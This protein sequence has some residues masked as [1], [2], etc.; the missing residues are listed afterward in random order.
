MPSILAKIESTA[1]A[2]FL[3]SQCWNNA[4][5]SQSLVR[6][7]HSSQLWCVD[8]AARNAKRR[9][10]YANDPEYR[11]RKLAILRK[12]RAK[13]MPAKRSQHIQEYINNPEYRETLRKLYEARNEVR[14]KEAVNQGLA[15]LYRENRNNFKQ[16]NLLLN[17]LMGSKWLRRLAWE[18][19]EPLISEDEK[20][21]AV[22]ASCN[23][24]RS[25]K[26]WWRRKEIDEKSGKQLLDCHSCFC[27]KDW[28]KALPLGYRGHVFGNGTRLKQPDWENYP[29]SAPSP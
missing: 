5:P 16:K 25:R 2:S 17:N 10:R 12:S 19:H 13:H 1:R 3:Y 8:S 26:L 22:C 28:E 11:Q 23:F 27:D 7:F 18:T 6:F 21:P 9:E 15:I 29:P 14:D 4:A 20:V 24:A